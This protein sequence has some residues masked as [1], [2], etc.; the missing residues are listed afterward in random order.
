M[1]PV[2]PCHPRIQAIQEAAP[3]GL[4]E[5]YLLRYR[6]YGHHNDSDIFDTL[7]EYWTDWGAFSGP[8]F[9]HQDLFPWDC[10][11]AYRK[12]SEDE[13][14][15]GTCDTAKHL[16]AFPF[17]SWSMIQLHLFRE[18]RHYTSKSTDIPVLSDIEWTSN[19]LRVLEALQALNAVA[20]A[21]AKSPDFRERCK[22]AFQ[23]SAHRLPPYPEL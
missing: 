19:R 7:M 6:R 8:I 13:M 3:N 2:G 16:W 4:T 15:C 23:D 21:L 5:E 10:S 22:W 9:S 14:K 18:R 17:D 12:G 20:T 1:T 11:E